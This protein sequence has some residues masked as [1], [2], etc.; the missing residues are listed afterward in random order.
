MQLQIAVSHKRVGI[1]LYEYTVLKTPTVY[2][3]IIQ[4][5]IIVTGATSQ[6]SCENETST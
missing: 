2:K 6:E 4:I 1:V 5:A 3:D